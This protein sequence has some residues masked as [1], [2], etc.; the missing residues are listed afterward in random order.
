MEPKR[1]IEDEIKFRELY[2]SPLRLFGWVYPYFFLL[3][4]IFG[5]YFG[6]NIIKISFNEV[7]VGTQDTTNVKK[8]IVE[9]KGGV[10]PAVDLA[11]L[12]NPTQAMINN[13]KKLYDANC[14]SCHGATGMGDGPAG[15]ALN[16]KPRNYHDT[17]GWTNGRNF[18]EMYKTLQEGI[19][20]T[21]MTAFEYIPPSDRV[22]I[23]FYIR[24]FADFPLIT[25]DQISNLDAAYH[26]S[27]GTIAPSQIPVAKAEQKLVEENAVVASK[28][29]FI[30]SRLNSAVDSQG[31]KLLR[32]STFNM[33]KVLK[34]FIS[35]HGS[36]FDQ[37]VL[38][39]SNS[40]IMQG[41][42]PSVLQLSKEQWEVLY[43]YLKS[44]MT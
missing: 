20:N 2:K 21:G 36:T 24:T 17:G 23:I 15:G 11:S 29:Y 34:S 13:G 42:K 40:P 10:T 32:L 44:L 3:L 28:I 9:K 8:E 38:S 26:L 27:E 7:P 31:L 37:Y 41:Y 4:L 5:I 33:E 1:K 14:Q 30:K 16:P 43:D 12:K 18:D 6:H 22:D 25:D 35:M 19:P 39:V